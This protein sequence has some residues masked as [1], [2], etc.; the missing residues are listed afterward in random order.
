VSLSVEA[1]GYGKYDG[2][3]VFT[4]PEYVSENSVRI[5]FT[6]EVGDY[7]ITPATTFTLWDM[8]V[9]GT[10]HD[11]G[12]YESSYYQ[13]C[14]RYAVDVDIEDIQ[15]PVSKGEE[16]LI[17][18]TYDAKLETLENDLGGQVDTRN[19][20]IVILLFLLIVFTAVILYLL[21][22][23]PDFTLKT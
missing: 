8:T 15:V 2:I 7:K 22:I 16:N 14:S 23:R 9:E 10:P 12:D 1:G 11:L 19:I 18:D 20:V 3:I 4:F 5:H 17:K 21:F 13:I 6:G